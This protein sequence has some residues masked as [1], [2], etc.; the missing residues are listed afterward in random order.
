MRSVGFYLF[1][2]NTIEYVSL[3]L[4]TTGRPLQPLIIQMIIVSRIA[5]FRHGQ[6][7]SRF[8]H[9]IEFQSHDALCAYILAIF[10]EF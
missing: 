3:N 2:A 9:L 1:F 6:I 5:V 10:C 4:S 7:A 8:E